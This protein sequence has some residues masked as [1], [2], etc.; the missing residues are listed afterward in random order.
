MWD[1]DDQ[2]EF[3]P[4]VVKRISDVKDKP[5]YTK[6]L[7]KLSYFVQSIL[8][9]TEDTNTYVFKLWDDAIK[10]DDY[11]ENFL[12]GLLYHFALVRPQRIEFI[13]NLLTT[14]FIYFPSFEDEISQTSFLYQIYL[15]YSGKE[16]IYNLSAEFDSL[17]IH[18]L[19]KEDRID[20]IQQHVNK[21]A[22]YNFD[23]P[24]YISLN[25]PIYFL[26]PNKNRIK[27]KTSLL[28]LS[29]FYG[30]IKCFKFFLLNDI[31]VKQ[32][33][34][35]YS[36]AGGN[37]EII[38]ILE[39]KGINFNH[40]YVIPV[41]FN[42][43]YLCEWLLLHYKCEYVPQ[44]ICLSSYNYDAFFFSIINTMH[45]ENNSLFDS[46]D[47]SH[48]ALSFHYQTLFHYVI[49]LHPWNVVEMILDI[50]KKNKSHQTVNDVFARK[51]VCKY[52]KLE[53]LKF[54]ID[55]KKEYEKSIGMSQSNKNDGLLH[56]VAKIGKLDFMKYLIEEEGYSIRS[57]DQNHKT[58][59][60]YGLESSN[61]EV[62]DYLMS[63]VSKGIKDEI[64]V[65]KN[66]ELNKGLRTFD[67]SKPIQDS[68][69]HN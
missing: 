42:R 53:Q 33:S 55:N 5:Q 17:S 10:V 64:S 47:Q 40:C 48:F 61:N 44:T 56:T 20:D 30:S 31:E 49:Y 60:D 63:L 22:S 54:L 37:P 51:I 25:S 39:Q 26:I 43:T 11:N 15:K 41:R 65:L 50:T 24:V 16:K 66:T 62:V 46:K 8:D 68:I 18:S 29:A 2:N 1:S 12:I 23:S 67:Y 52:G 9:S 58:P 27:Y 14:S 13:Y 7:S 19:I 28:D 3:I 69:L 32:T 4:C 6:Y 21:T 35:W 38:H 59:F 34:S 36:L 45:F 57:E